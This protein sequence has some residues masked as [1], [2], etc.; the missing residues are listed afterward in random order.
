MTS[1][2]PICL[3]RA[4]FR[5]GACAVGD[6]AL[7]GPLG[8]DGLLSQQARRLVC[9]F[10]GQGSFAKASASLQEACG[11]SL[12]DEAI[13]QACYRQA[14]RVQRWVDADEQTCQAFLR[15]AG[16]VELQIDAAKVN[17]TDGWRDMKIAV[18]AKRQRGEPA[19]P[20]RWDKR[21]LPKPTA[22]VAFA[23]VEEAERFGGRLGDWTERLQVDASQVSVLGDGAE[24]IWNIALEHVPGARHCLDIYHGCE[25][26]SDAA[27]ALF[28]QGSEPAAAWLGQAR[29]RLLADGWWGLCE[30][31]G[32]TLQ[33]QGEPARGALEELWGYFSKQTG[34]L[35]YCARLY[36]G[37]AIGSGLVEGACKNVIGRRL[38]QTAARWKLDNV[39]RMAVLCCCA[40][41]D[42]WAPYWNAA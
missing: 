7:D 13:R 5:C 32:Q 9:Y 39:Q 38:K 4:Y 26:L 30:Q 23:R 20:E 42:F 12:S 14:D 33:D 25:Y 2:G 17:T 18:Y 37:Q 24:W 41:S 27:K 11:W 10:A 29:Q 15:A 3:R 31:V 28:G 8:A 34:R 6:Y 36:A 19:T 21:D 1:L 16:D 22:R 35:G 40:Y